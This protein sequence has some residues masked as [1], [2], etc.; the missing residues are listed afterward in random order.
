MTEKI[1][2]KELI[3]QIDE[4]LTRGVSSFIDPDGNF[5]QK[6]LRKASG[7]T[8]EEIVIKFGVDPTRP[9]IH[10]GHA[11]V[12]RKL[13]QLQDLGCKVIFL[14]GDFTT[15]IGDPTGKSKARPE[16]DQKEV[17]ANVRTYLDQVGKVLS[18]D[19]R[20]FAWIRNS[21]WFFGVTDVSAEGASKESLVWETKDVAGNPVKI[22]LDPDYFVGKALLYEK[23]R[24]Q[25]KIFPAAPVRGVSLV[26]LLAVL[27]KI[28]HAQ[29][30]ERDM[31]AD[32]IAK[33]E[34]LFMHEMLYPV[35]QGID[36]DILAGIFGSCDLEVGGSDQTFNMLMGRKVME[37]TNRAPQA[38]LAFDLLVGTDGTEKM[39]KSLDNYVG[40]TDLPADMYGKIMSV[41]DSALVSY[42]KLATFTPIGDIAKIEKKLKDGK[43]NPRDLKMELARQIVAIYHGEKAATE[44]EGAFVGTFQKGKL[45]DDIVTHE[46][47]KGT[48]LVDAVLAAGIVASK[49]EFRRL[50]DEGAVS[51]W[52]GERISDPALTVDKPL[53]LKV[54]K[55]RFLRI[56]I[57]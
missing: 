13:R 8:K 20:V 23:T 34:P 39:S 52:E 57:K 55:R 42:Y 5:R 51:E 3:E 7:Q 54:G 21:D 49:G 27:R 2:S 30:V 4:I 45:P 35:A 50:I 26:N 46:A 10:L 56:E 43:T 53:I 19:T 1:E 37:M 29:L 25:N 28:T 17:E 38:V 14:V 12:F 18:L 36:S 16:L 48:P 15:L 32:R 41:P 33:G 40:V 22:S 47:A 6:L 24:M 11:V 44:A 31:F 9:D